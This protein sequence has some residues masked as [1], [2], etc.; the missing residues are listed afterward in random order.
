MMRQIAGWFSLLILIFCPAG[1]WARPVDLAEAERAARTADTPYTVTLTSAIQDAQGNAL[2]GP[3]SWAFKTGPANTSWVRLTRHFQDFLW[4]QH[5]DGV[6]D[7]LVVEVEVSV[8]FT[9]TYNL[10]GWLLDKNGLGIARATTG[11]F[12]WRSGRGEI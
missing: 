8:L 9:G 5:G 1:L 12:L 10:S 2:E 7:T 3:F 11:S 6:W 4:D